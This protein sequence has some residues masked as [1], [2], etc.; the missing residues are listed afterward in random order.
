MAPNSLQALISPDGG[1]PF[2][3]GTP[4][5][6][7]PDSILA[8][9]KLED[10]SNR[11]T[12]EKVNHRAMAGPRKSSKTVISAALTKS[13]DLPR[14]GGRKVTRP[15]LHQELDCET[16][17]ERFDSLQKLSRNRQSYIQTTKASNSPPEK[18]HDPAGAGRYLSAI[19]SNRSS[20]INF[21]KDKWRVNSALEPAES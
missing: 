7:D 5:M 18:T 1:L 3:A 8:R 10:L 19:A 21:E 16:V 17:L 11:I 20:K 12:L 15:Q 2:L 6:P 9:Y 14:V 13:V 4:M